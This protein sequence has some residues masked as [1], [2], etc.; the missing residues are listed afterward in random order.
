MNNTFAQVGFYN[1][2]VGLD[3]NRQ[4]SETNHIQSNVYLQFKPFSWLT[5]KSLYG[6]D[7]LFVDNEIFHR[8]YMAMVL[9]PWVSIKYLREI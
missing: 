9:R 3:Q 7:Y 1:P 2:V 6:I 8:P 5:L 4:N